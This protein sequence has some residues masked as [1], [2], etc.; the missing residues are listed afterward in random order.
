VTC[1]WSPGWQG[2]NGETD[3]N[4]G[5]FLFWKGVH[6]HRG[7]IYIKKEYSQRRKPMKSKIFVSLL[8][9]LVMLFALAVPVMAG[10]L[11]KANVEVYGSPAVVVGKCS[12]Q[13]TRNDLLK[14]TVSLSGA[15][16]GTYY[17]TWASGSVNNPTDL[18]LSGPTL[19]SSFTVN[20]SGRGR[21]RGFA[22]GHATDCFS[23]DPGEWGIQIFIYDDPS[24]TWPPVY[25][26]EE[27]VCMWVTFK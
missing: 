15:E 14:I 10:K 6:L 27:G 22:S 9:A 11:A 1:T 4:I 13:P 19:P 5:R 24:L 20:Q 18:S 23:T 17:I 2:A 16:P 8:V 25:E 26:S 12:A 21:F 3:L 7:T